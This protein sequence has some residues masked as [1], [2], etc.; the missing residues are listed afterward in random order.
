LV[1]ISSGDVSAAMSGADA[2]VAAGEIV[3]DR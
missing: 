2:L 1:P 3:R